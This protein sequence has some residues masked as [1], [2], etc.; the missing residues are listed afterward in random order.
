M[1]IVYRVNRITRKEKLKIRIT[2]VA[3]TLA[4]VKLTKKQH[5]EFFALLIDLCMQYNILLQKEIIN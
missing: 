3:N 2:Q 4:H 1:V 5:E